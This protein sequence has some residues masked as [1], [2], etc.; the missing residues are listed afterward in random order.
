MVPPCEHHCQAG[1]PSWYLE[2]GKLPTFRSRAPAYEFNHTEVRGWNPHLLLLEDGE[3]VVYE[4]RET[5]HRIS[6]SYH[7]HQKIIC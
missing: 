7:V 6:A 2:F 5:F 1:K 4:P 3:H